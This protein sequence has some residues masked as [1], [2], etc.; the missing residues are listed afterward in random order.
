MRSLRTGVLV[1]S[2]IVP[3]LRVIAV[4]AIV[5]VRNTSVL[6][7]WIDEPVKLKAVTNE[8]VA[9]AKQP[10]PQVSAHC[11]RPP[12]TRN[13]TVCPLLLQVKFARA[14]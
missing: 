10:L 13:A 5:I 12:N 3:I 2:A 8:A 7:G 1:G 9:Q 4:G 11:S 6:A 14:S